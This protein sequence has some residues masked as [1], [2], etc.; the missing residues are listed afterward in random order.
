M[1]RCIV[2]KMQKEILNP[3]EQ[4]LEETS[5]SCPKCGN[6]LI[7][8]QENIHTIK[9]CITESFDIKTGIVTAC[10]YKKVM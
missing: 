2:D 3:I 9:Y 8:K 7:T 6:T 4:S 5:D 10:G 1:Q